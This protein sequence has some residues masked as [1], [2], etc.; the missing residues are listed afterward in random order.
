MHL[1][2]F[3]CDFFLRNIPSFARWC[4]DYRLL[5]LVQR[6]CL[7]LNITKHSAFDFRWNKFFA[8]LQS[9][10]IRLHLV[11]LI[12]VLF[13]SFKYLRQW[14]IA[15]QHFFPGLSFCWQSFATASIISDRVWRVGQR[16]N[17][18]K[19]SYLIASKKLDT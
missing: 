2:D 13:L 8:T 15:L 11:Y 17:L 19:L 5:W 7:S 3:E 12:S 1:Y 10:R 9:K 14:T 16:A 18:V 4:G 6:I